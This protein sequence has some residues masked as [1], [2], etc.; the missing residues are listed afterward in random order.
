MFN[1]LLVCNLMILL[2]YVKVF[3]YFCG[4][5]EV[6]FEDLCQVLFFVFNDKLYFDVDVLFFVLFENVVYWVDWLS[7]LW[8]LFDLLNEEF[9]WFDFDCYDLV[10]DLGDEFVQGF[11]GLVESEVC[12]WLL[13]IE[14]L[15]GEYGKGCKFYGYF[16]DDLL[17]F[18]YLYQCYINYL[19]W[20]WLC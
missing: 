10:G 5:G 4:D 9:D 2:K 14:W 13:W 6:D 7:W 20:L 8:Y 3:V 15:V 19:I 11:D 18:K 16:Y 17:W 12:L 1:G